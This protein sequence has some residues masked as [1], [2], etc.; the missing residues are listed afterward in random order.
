MKSKNK[1]VKKRLKNLNKLLGIAK[2]G[3]LKDYDYKK[4]KSLDK[5]YS[6]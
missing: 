6:K 2:N 1:K 3:E 4:E 5:R